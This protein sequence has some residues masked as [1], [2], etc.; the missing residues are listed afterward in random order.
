MESKTPTGHQGPAGGGSEAPKR[1]RKRSVIQLSESW[2][3]GG[4]GL[5]QYGGAE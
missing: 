5:F 3:A 1:A 2:S 4:A